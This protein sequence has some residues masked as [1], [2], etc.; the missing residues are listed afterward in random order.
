MIRWDKPYTYHIPTG[1][2]FRNHPRQ[3]IFVHTFMEPT[4]P[5]PTQVLNEVHAAVA[6]EG[7][8]CSAGISGSTK[9]HPE[10]KPG[11]SIGSTLC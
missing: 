3:M 9:S 8:G 11:P 1:A 4:I 10:M 5:W 6:Q 2:G 7:Q